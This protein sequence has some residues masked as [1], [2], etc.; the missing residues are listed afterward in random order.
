[1]IYATRISYSS[2]S[3]DD[4]VEDVAL[5]TAGNYTEA[6]SK[7][8]RDYN[9]Q[10]IL[11]EKLTLELINDTDILTLPLDFDIEGLKELQ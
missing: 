1:M 7:V 8:E 2:K 11:I 6:A 3:T 4:L 5:V 9:R 10:N